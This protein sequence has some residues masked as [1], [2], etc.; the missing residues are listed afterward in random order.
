VPAD[1]NASYDWPAIERAIGVPLPG[2]YKL[3]V[4]LLP[5]GWWRGFVRPLRPGMSG[6]GA[7]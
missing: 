2:D 4:E 1:L 7:R 5:D 6:D 3:L